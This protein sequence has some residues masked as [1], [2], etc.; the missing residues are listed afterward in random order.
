MTNISTLA[1]QPVIMSC[2]A[3]GRPKPQLYWF[4]GDH[5][6]SA[7]NP[8]EHNNFRIINNGKMLTLIESSVRDAGEYLCVAKSVAG[9]RSIRFNVTVLGN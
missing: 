9:E 7:L 5:N 8:E 1:G 6:L 4:R 3:T 2:S